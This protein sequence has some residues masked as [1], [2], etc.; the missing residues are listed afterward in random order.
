MGDMPRPVFDDI[1]YEQAVARSGRLLFELLTAVGGRLSS[2]DKKSVIEEHAEPLGTRV[3]QALERHGELSPRELRSLL[4]CSSMTLSRS[5]KQL[6]VEDRV[7]PAGNTRGRH[8]TLKTK[9]TQ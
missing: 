6:V 2:A 3:V 5:L 4:R 9:L 8:Y 7:V 1:S